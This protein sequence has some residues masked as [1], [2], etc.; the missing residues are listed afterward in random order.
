MNILRDFFLLL[1]AVFM[2]TGCSQ[3]IK[4]DIARQSSELIHCEIAFGSDLT[5]LKQENAILL[6]TGIIDTTDEQ[7]P[8]AVAI[9]LIDR[10]EV[11][12]KSVNHHEVENETSRTY[13]GEGYKLNLSYKMDI[14]QNNETIFKGKFVIEKGNLKSEYDIVGSI[15]NL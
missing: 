7:A 4:I 10:K 9:V 12:L 8:I 3:A 14:S 13:E 11:V 1:I 15:C 5:T 2:L 6:Q